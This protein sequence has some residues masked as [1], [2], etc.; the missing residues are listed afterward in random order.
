MRFCIRRGSWACRDLPSSCMVLES[1]ECHYYYYPGRDDRN[2]GGRR[3]QRRFN[4]RI[5]AQ[6]VH[7]CLVIST[8]PG[9]NFG[10]LDESTR[11][12]LLRPTRETDRDPPAEEEVQPPTDS[13]HHRSRPRASTSPRGLM[14]D[15]IASLC[16]RHDLDPWSSTGTRRSC[17]PSGETLW[18]PSSHDVF[19]RSMK[20]ISTDAGSFRRVRG[21]ER[22][23]RPEGG[24]GTRLLPLY[25][26]SLQRL[27]PWPR[28]TGPSILT[29][30]APGRWISSS[31]APS[32]LGVL[33]RL[34]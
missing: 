15:I 24:C 29:Q 14:V 20:H 19:C 8:C 3:I 16:A 5:T 25:A 1:L 23:K 21:R 33:E 18:N 34:L 22:L 7:R 26:S 30:S 2:H 32:L 12:G 10:A 9:S 17:S 31:L 11:R 27:S 4:A 28:P 13:R 6:A